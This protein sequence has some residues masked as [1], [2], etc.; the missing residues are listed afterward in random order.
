MG[1]CVVKGGAHRF[2]G[3]ATGNGWAAGCY[4]ERQVA[5]FCAMHTHLTAVCYAQQR[6]VFRPPR[7]GDFPMPPTHTTVVSGLI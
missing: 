3:G 5:G 2:P 1:K 7:N 4:G 6:T